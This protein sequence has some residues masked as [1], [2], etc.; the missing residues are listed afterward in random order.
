MP[1]TVCQRGS[2]LP[3]TVVL[4]SVENAWTDF[5]CQINNSSR[6]AKTS[7]IPKRSHLHSGP[8][9]VIIIW[10]FILEEGVEYAIQD[11]YDSSMKWLL[12]I[13]IGAIYIFS[14]TFQC[15]WTPGEV[16]FVYMTARH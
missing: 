16:V 5:C 15:T 12:R 10:V 13:Q 14:P 6:L 7:S 11:G 1:I 9:K 8:P 4:A 3:P 2:A